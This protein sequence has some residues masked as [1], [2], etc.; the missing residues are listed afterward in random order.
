MRSSGNVNTKKLFIAV[1]SAWTF[2]VFLT[3]GWN[4]YTEKTH[5][6]AAALSEAQTHFNKDKAFR[7]WGSGHGG[8]Y[9][10][11]DRNTPPNEHLKHLPERDL[12]TPSGRNLTLMNPAY[13]VSQMMNQY[14]KTYG[15]KGHITS[16]SDKL[17]N[18]ANAPDKWELEALNAFK[19]G[20]EEVSGIENVDGAS[21]MRLT[22]PMFI[23]ESCL[24]C[25]GEQGYQVGDLRGAVGVSVPM[26]PY[27]KHEASTLGLLYI[28]YGPLWLLGLL[29]QWFAYKMVKEKVIQ[30]YRLQTK[31]NKSNTKLKAF[32]YQ[33]SLTHIANRRLFDAVLKREWAAARRHKS[34]LSL[35]M[36]DIDHFKEYNDGYGHQAGDY[37]LSRIA[38]CLNTV[39]KRNTDLVARYGGEEFV[40]LLPQTEMEQALKI[41]NACHQAVQKMHI[42]H[43]YADVADIV[44]VSIGVASVYP[45]RKI[46]LEALV[47]IADAAMYHAKHEG[48]NRVKVA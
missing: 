38:D 36:I 8:V 46:K 40:I 41:A 11:A 6:Y 18:P 1:A 9:V 19:Q 24:N 14:E 20:V 31:L 13:M 22:K 17:F 43:D 37:C 35:L 2:L 15:V 33:D 48:R 7:L 47:E 42:P 23:V 25:H 45:D 30:Q 32:S 26:T 5:T 39:V 16:F 3:L 21:F 10:P 28:S 44:T 34:S 27:T 29:G 12:V 4:I